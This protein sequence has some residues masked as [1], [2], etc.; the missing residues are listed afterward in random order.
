MHPF[1]PTGDTVNI[2]VA[3]SSANVQ[4]EPDSTI[5]RKIRVMN[6]GTATVWIRFGADS[7]VA[8]SASKDIPIGSGGTE[9]FTVHATP[10][11]VAAIAAAS[12]GSIYF[13]PGE[14]I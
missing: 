5:W 14:G 3:S 4:I 10:I 11:W 9:V 7:S 12:T 8:A 6:N 1:K 13:T 2:A